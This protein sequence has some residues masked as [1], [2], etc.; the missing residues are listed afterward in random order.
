MIKLK[1]NKTMFSAPKTVINYDPSSLLN[2]SV[3]FLI[4]LYLLNLEFNPNPSQINLH[5]MHVNTKERKINE[6]NRVIGLVNCFIWWD[7]IDYV[8]NMQSHPDS[9]N[10]INISE[11]WGWI[12]RQTAWNNVNSRLFNIKNFPSSPK[13][14][15]QRLDSIWIKFC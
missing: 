5:T 11:G 6:R 10:Q 12:I 13:S 7:Q 2:I 9:R 8:C 15:W 4:L 3:A 1:V 14:L